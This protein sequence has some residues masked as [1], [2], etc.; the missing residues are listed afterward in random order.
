M[1]TDYLLY[2]VDI[3]FTVISLEF[4]THRESLSSMNFIPTFFDI[5]LVSQ[6]KNYR[7][8]SR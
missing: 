5:R 4:S 1:L 2:D 6:T 7:N 3:M 8:E